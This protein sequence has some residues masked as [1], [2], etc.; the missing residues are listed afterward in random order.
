MRWREWRT[1]ALQEDLYVGLT[2]AGTG[3]DASL[4]QVHD[5]TSGPAAA[6]TGT[7]RNDLRPPATS[8]P[9]LYI[10][11]SDEKKKAL[12]QEFDEVAAIE[13]VSHFEAPKILV[14]DTPEQR[15]VYKNLLNEQRKFSKPTL[16]VIDLRK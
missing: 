2:N 11:G 14:V 6:V 15:E 10:V 4:V 9:Q 8:V 1:W 5:L 13:G 3:F 16:E 12:V 7:R